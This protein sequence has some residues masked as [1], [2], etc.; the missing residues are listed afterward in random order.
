M[1]RNQFV[2]FRFVTVPL[3]NKEDKSMEKGE[4]VWVETKGGIF[5][6]R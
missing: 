4:E 3:K 1:W 6:R 5:R 2:S